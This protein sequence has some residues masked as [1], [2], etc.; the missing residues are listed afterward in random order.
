L[1]QRDSSFCAVSH[2]DQWVTLKTADDGLT[3]NPESGV[4]GAHYT[5]ARHDEFEARLTNE[6]TFDVARPP[7]ARTM[8]PRCVSRRWVETYRDFARLIRL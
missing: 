6:L 3:A 1:N 5:R 4:R 7:R 8:L 2:I